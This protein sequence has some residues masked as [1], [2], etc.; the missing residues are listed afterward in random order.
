M[1]KKYIL[2]GGPGS[3]KSSIVLALEDMGEH[4]IREAAED[5]IRREQARGYKEPWFEKGFQ[6]KIL[7][8]QIQREERIPKEAERCFLDRGIYDGLAYSEKGSEIFKRIRAMDQGYEGKV[9]LVE[10]RGSTEKTQVRRES[11][12]EALEVERN[13]ER[14]YKELGYEVIRIPDATVEERT[15]LVLENL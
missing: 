11:Q 1:T 7:G 8:L 6:E 9:F 10:N 2:T 3:G 14:I 15:K 12:E 4:I 5:V 13:L